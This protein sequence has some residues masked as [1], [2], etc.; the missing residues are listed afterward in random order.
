MSDSQVGGRGELS[1]A[2]VSLTLLQASYICGE[3]LTWASGLKPHTVND[4]L[5]E[6]GRKLTGTALLRGVALLLE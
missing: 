5:N 1:T 6:C 4:S 3:P 2:S